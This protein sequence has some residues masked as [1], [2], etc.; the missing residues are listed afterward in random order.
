MDVML[1]VL[2]NSP[3]GTGIR[4]ASRVS[5]TD[6]RI[7]AEL[8]RRVMQLFEA[9]IAPYVRDR[10]YDWEIHIDETPFDCWQVQGLAPPTPK[11]EG[12][13]L[14]VRENRPVP[15]ERV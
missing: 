11:S 2:T 13:T 8:R 5:P 10:R 15:H 12:E 7:C 14:W 3:L 9:Q 4:P 1:S 6:F